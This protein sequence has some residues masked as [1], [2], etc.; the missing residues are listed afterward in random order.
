MEWK[1]G[2]APPV[3]SGRKFG[4]SL[5]ANAAIDPRENRLNRCRA[6]ARTKTVGTGGDGF[7]NVDV[8]G[9]YHHWIGSQTGSRPNTDRLTRSNVIAGRYFFLVPL[10]SREACNAMERNQADTPSPIREAA[11]VNCVFC[12]A[13]TRI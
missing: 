10:S 13:V 5:L 1:V 3:H 2:A 6:S 11:F 8:E 9:L 7:G 12:A 4:L